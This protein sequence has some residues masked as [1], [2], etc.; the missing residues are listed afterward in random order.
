MITK[1]LLDT[2]KMPF[3]KYIGVPMQDVPAQYLH[4]LWTNVRDPMRNKVK[5]DPVANYI[6]CN[7]NALK[8]EYPDGI[9]E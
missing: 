4:W 9:W 1:L 7:L 6:N 8:Q 3:G 2:D 5:D